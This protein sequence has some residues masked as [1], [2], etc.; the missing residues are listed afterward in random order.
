MIK[1][2]CYYRTAPRTEDSIPRMGVLRGLR[3]S[4]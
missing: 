4:R 1:L 3:L 2:S